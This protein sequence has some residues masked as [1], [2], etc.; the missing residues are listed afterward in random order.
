MPPLVSILI[1]AYNAGCWL[2]E[3]IESALGQT[4]SRLEVIVVDDGSSDNTLA[5]ARHFQSA[6]VKVLTHSNQG[7]SAKIT[8]FVQEKRLELIEEEYA[9]PASSEIEQAPQIARRLPQQR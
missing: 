3:S 4:W 5:V 9:G 1:P 2:A 6:R 7:A 8:R